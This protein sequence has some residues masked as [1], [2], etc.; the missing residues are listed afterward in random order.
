[1][2]R[3]QR[4]R[5]VGL[6]MG[7][8]VALAAGAAPALATDEPAAPGFSPGS[9]IFN[10]PD[11]TLFF[12][13]DRMAA[14]GAKWVRL[15]IPW[16]SIEEVE[17]RFYW[18]STDRLVH[19][20]RQRGMRVVG[21]LHTA[22]S[23]ARAPGTSFLSPPRDL[24]KWTRFVRAAVQRYAANVT[25]WE[26]WN[27]PNISLFWDPQPD[28]ATYTALLKETYAA[29]HG[30][31]AGRTVLFGGL[32][33]AADRTDGKEISPLTF[34]RRVYAE[35]GKGSF[36]A[37]AIHPYSYPALPTDPTTS[38]WNQFQKLPEI[39]TVMV[40]NGDGHK[41]VWLTE[42]GAPTGTAPGAVT[43]QTQAASVSEAYKAAAQ[44]TWVGPLLWYSHRDS[45]TDLV[46]REQNFGLLHHDFTPKS[47]VRTFA[48]TTG[49]SRAPI[50]DYNGDGKTDVAVFRPST[51]TW[52][53]RGGNPA[54]IGFGIS[55]DVPVADVLT[56]TLL[57]RLRP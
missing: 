20:A 24:Q 43:E 18:D 31:A 37:M 50:G 26:V 28:P 57:L 39:R 44:W 7:V 23:W 25:V 45:G 48:A 19:A 11:M 8:T 12:D 9:F 16:A 55:T 42:Y 56:R 2:V 14:L 33:P 34:L 30:S 51:G 5:S 3:K 15:D 29:V 10:E 53:I 52:Y 47:A 21:I 46:D 27:E 32:A 54:E 13:M 17:G 49:V 36:D 41:K 22:P 38:S 1:M 35:G 40:E 6:M 4:Y